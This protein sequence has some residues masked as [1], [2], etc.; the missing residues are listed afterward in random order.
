MKEIV[1]NKH[2]FFRKEDALNEYQFTCLLFGLSNDPDFTV[3]YYEIS[4]TV[5]DEW[6]GEA[7][8]AGNL[9]PKRLFNFDND[10]SSSAL[11]S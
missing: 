8:I 10:L 2:L 3:V 5:N 1:V 7:I 9:T 6:G 11:K 4:I